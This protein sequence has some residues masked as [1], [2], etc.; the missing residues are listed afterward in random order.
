MGL[1]LLILYSALVI[2]PPYSNQI[3]PPEIGNKQTF[4]LPDNYNENLDKKT[5]YGSKTGRWF[6]SNKGGHVGFSISAGYQKNGSTVNAELNEGLPNKDVR[7]RLTKLDKSFR[8]ILVLDEKIL[9]SKKNTDKISYSKQLLQNQDVLYLL[10]VEVLG[11]NKEVEDTLLS[12]VC[13]PIQELNSSMVLD[14]QKYTDEETM[15]LN[16]K[17]DGPTEIMTGLPYQIQKLNM[18][19]WEVVHNKMAFT[20]QGIRV[21]P[22]EVYEQKISLKDL[23]EGNYRILKEVEVLQIKEPKMTLSA[24]FEVISK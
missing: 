21:Q 4:I 5:G 15:E 19:K 18:N 12:V 7:F 24:E 3:P 13:V 2:Y 20:L 17:N 11:E 22:G 9:S 23:S 1:L 10:S 8:P 14:K 6:L 16:I